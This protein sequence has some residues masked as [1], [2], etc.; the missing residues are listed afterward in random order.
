V[1]FYV[2]AYVSVYINVYIKLKDKIKEMVNLKDVS[3]KANVSIATVSRYIN[4]VGFISD[5][6]KLRIEKAI[7]DLNYI[8]NRVAQSLS[9][10][11]TNTIGIIVPNIANPYFPTMIKGASSYL[12]EKGYHVHLCNT[13]NEVEKEDF[14]LKD[15]QSKCVDGA[16][17][18]LPAY[19]KNKK[20]S[21]EIYNELNYPKIIVGR[22]FEGVE[23]DYLLINDEQSSFEA[24]KYLIE[25]GHKK[26]VFLG[27]E[28][29]IVASQERY[30]GWKKAMKSAELRVNNYDFWG[31]FSA[32]SGSEM[33]KKAI[34]KLE[35]ID[36]VFAANDLIAIGAI[37]AIRDVGL[38]VPKD[39]S[40][41]GFDDI[42]LSKYLYPSLSTVKQPTFEI[43]AKSAELL[44][45]RIKSSSR[46]FITLK[47]NCEL[48][49]RDSVLEKNNY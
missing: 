4:N 9:R 14:F 39:I 41:M 17:I 23:A 20:R 29:F 38:D 8:P 26:I 37:K 24:T 42:Y 13:D 49:I 31:N 47:L 18:L 16:I 43:G 35:K 11:S 44:L 10:Q 12:F 45:N 3:N 36:A 27:G 25:K 33:M 19:S 22:K 32:K 40:V 1:Y 5:E 30:S 15:Y 6:L 46:D 48:I 21:T 7:K 2:N 28:K 34:R